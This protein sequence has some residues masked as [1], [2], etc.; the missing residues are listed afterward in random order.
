MLGSWPSFDPLNFTQFKPNDP[1]NPSKTTPVTYCPT[2]DRTLPPP[3][4]VIASEAK[5]ILVRNFYQQA[6]VKLRTKRASCDNPITERP[7]KV[8]RVSNENP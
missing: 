4:Q 8:P 3:D 1:S 5:N 7:S 2:H 6:E